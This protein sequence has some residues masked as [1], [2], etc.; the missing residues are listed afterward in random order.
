MSRNMSLPGRESGWTASIRARRL[1]PA[2]RP[3]TRPSRASAGT[4]RRAKA[5][6]RRRERF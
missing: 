1:R 6:P 2:D 4:G 5:R 3:Q